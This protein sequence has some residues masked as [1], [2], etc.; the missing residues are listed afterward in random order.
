MYPILNSSGFFL[1]SL[2]II[3]IVD[4]VKMA[5]HIDGYMCQIAQGFALFTIAQALALAFGV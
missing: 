5:F 4:H 3:L 2:T 1:L